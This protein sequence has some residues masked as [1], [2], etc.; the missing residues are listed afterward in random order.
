[1][2]SSFAICSNTRLLLIRVSA[3]GRTCSFNPSI[4]IPE[5]CMYCSMERPLCAILCANSLIMFS[6]CVSIIASGIS[7]VDLSMIFLIASSSFVRF[8][9]FS[10]S[11]SRCFLKSSLYSANVSNS[12]TSEANSSFNSGSS[13]AL[14]SLILTLNTAGFP[15]KSAA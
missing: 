2:F 6:H 11:T 1:M 8:A 4:V 5:N 15:A 7:I 12:D 9:S 13:F 14:I 3:S 10:F